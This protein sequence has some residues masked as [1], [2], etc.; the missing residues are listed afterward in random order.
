MTPNLKRASQVSKGLMWLL[1]MV[2][3]VVSIYL[4]LET[5][6]LVKTQ[7]QVTPKVETVV[8]NQKADVFC[9]YFISSYF[10]QS[11][12]LEDYLSEKLSK[13][14]LKINKATPVSVLLENQ[15]IKGIQ[16]LLLMS[17]ISKRHK[18]MYQ[19]SA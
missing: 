14:D 5:L 9:R 17:L 7:P 4:S 6:Q 2:L 10:S 8:I 3:S 12:N 15:E 16:L 1:P 11:L 18:I 13:E 19:V